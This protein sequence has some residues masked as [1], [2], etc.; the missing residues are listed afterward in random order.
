MHTFR[1]LMAGWEPATRE[2]RIKTRPC[3]LG[4]T[5]GRV[6]LVKSRLGEVLPAPHPLPSAGSAG[7]L[8]AEC[9]DTGAPGGQQRSLLTGGLVLFF[10]RLQ[11][12]PFFP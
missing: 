2:I 4:R 12:F 5:L 1:R 6:T 9:Q 11:T 7:S 10:L 8:V 3:S